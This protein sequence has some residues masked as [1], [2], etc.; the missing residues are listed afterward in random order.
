MTLLWRNDFADTLVTLDVGVFFLFLLW[1]SLSDDRVS[2]CRLTG[3]Q[4]VQQTTRENQLTN[5]E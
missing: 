2:R 3:G 4:R 5:D 1:A